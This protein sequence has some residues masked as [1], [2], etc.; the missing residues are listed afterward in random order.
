MKHAVAALA[1]LAMGVGIIAAAEARGLQQQS[2]APAPNNMQGAQAGQ[3][4][5]DEQSVRQAQQQLKTQGLYKGEIDGIFGPQTRQALSKY[6]QR[7][8]LPQTATL[9]QGTLEHLMNGQAGQGVGVGSSTPPNS[10]APAAP[11][12]SPNAGN[13][14]QRY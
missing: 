13:G 5:Q 8:G 6:Q 3:A 10:N 11:A 9:D 14:N 4:Q 2:A 1:A 12:P 7:S